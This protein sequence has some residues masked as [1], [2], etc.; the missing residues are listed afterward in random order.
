[1]SLKKIFTAILL[2]FSILNLNAEIPKE[3]EGIWTGKDR[4]LFIN[5]NG[6]FS[7]ILKEY[8]GWYFDRVTEPDSFSSLL[9]RPRNAAS[10]PIP[11][12]NTVDFNRISDDLSAWEMKISIDE[13]EKFLI[14]VCVDENKLY[15]NL[16]IKVPYDESQELDTE[17]ETSSNPIYGYWQ[18]VNHSDSI[19]ISGR[20]NS[21][22][23]IS[24]Y[25][26][27]N[28]FYHLR[29]WPTKMEFEKAEAVFSDGN[30]L[31]IL[32]K[33]IFSAGQN[34][35]CVSGRSSNIRNVEKY[36][37]LPFSYKI[38]SS[39]NLLIIGKE[40]LVKNSE[41]YSAE[42]LMQIVKEANSRRKPP[43]PPLFP[44]E[45]LDWHWDLIRQ[46][47]KGNKIIE[48]VRERQREFEKSFQ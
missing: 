28:G 4:L 16:L 43:A 2:F 14:P 36:A 18:G 24:W 15:L 6:D 26:T 27:E 19:R 11:H 33:H 7:I 45:E 25:I 40:Y 35:S 17:E 48:G 39:E 32:N 23:I 41:Q 12:K 3:L 20:N 47:E 34:Y 31:Y 30:K 42:D 10:Q 22:N 44:E 38:N 1:M 5:E 46:L 21:E 8:Y 29:F 13:K 37:V 9:K